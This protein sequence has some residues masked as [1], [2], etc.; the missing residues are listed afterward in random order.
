MCLKCIPLP[1]WKITRAGHLQMEDALGYIVLM[2]LYWLPCYS[3]SATKGPMEFPVAC[4]PCKF[5]PR[6]HSSLSLPL[7]YD[8]HQTNTSETELLLLLCLK[9]SLASNSLK[10]KIGNF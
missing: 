2:P 8:Q 9:L 3:S 1:I 4:P 6:L 7:V 10:K 5:S